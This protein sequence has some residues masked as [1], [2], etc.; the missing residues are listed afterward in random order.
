MSDEGIGIHVIQQLTASAEY[1]NIIDF[2]DLGSSA[3]NVIHAIAGRKK[4]I[5]IDCA[6]MGEPVGTIK[7]FIPDQVVSDK[8]IKHL[9]LHEGDL[10]DALALSQKL[11]EC[12]EDI[13]IFG[14]EPE[15]M[16]FG[17]ALSTPLQEQLLEYTW[18]V[19]Q[20]L[21]GDLNA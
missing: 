4:A 2:V 16:S 1:S 10:L 11:G 8:N 9:S 13:V 7:R 18:A 6:Y 21:N 17:E 5:L 15:N 12:P 20:E 19:I 14:I 3:M